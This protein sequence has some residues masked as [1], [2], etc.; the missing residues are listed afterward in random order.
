V[1]DLSSIKYYNQARLEIES[2]FNGLPHTHTSLIKSLITRADPETGVVENISCREIAILLSVDPA[3]GR[4]GAGTPQIQTIRSYLRTISDNF[5][6]EFKLISQGQKLKCQFI[7]LPEIYANFFAQ[8]KEYGDNSEVSSTADR[9]ED[10]EK[11]GEI[12][13]WLDEDNTK[14]H[15]IKSQQKEPVKYINNIN[16]NNNN[17]QKLPISDNFT[18]SP[19]IIAR[20]QAL[21]YLNVTDFAEIQAFID[22]NKASGTLWADYNPIYLRWLTRSAERQTQFHIKKFHSGRVNNAGSK[23]HSTHQPNVRERVKQAYAREF[24]FDEKTG[25]FQGKQLHNAGYDCDTLAATC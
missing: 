16:N 3:P 24:D 17:L 19:A 2:R 11:S 7:N 18:P 6:N 8:E 21:G 13:L 14:D 1:D 25:C 5:S 12:D 4:K 23:K 10:T 9:I 22:H 15:P 20:A